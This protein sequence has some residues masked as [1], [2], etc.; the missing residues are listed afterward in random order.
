MGRSSFP[1]HTP[2][3][4]V[5]LLHLVEAQQHTAVSRLKDAATQA[6]AAAAAAATTAAASAAV[7]QARAALAV[8]RRLGGLRA[9]LQRT[10]VRLQR[11]QQQHQHQHQQHQQ[12]ANSTPKGGSALT[13]GALT[14]TACS[15]PP[16]LAAQLRAG[17]DCLQTAARVSPL[18]D[19]LLLCCDL[20]QLCCCPPSLGSEALHRLLQLLQ[21]V[22]RPQEPPELRAQEAALGLQLAALLVQQNAAEVAAAA[23]GQQTLSV[24]G[25]CIGR[26]QASIASAPASADASSSVD[27]PKEHSKSSLQEHHGAPEAGVR[28]QGAML[29]LSLLVSMQLLELLAHRKDMRR[30]L[31]LRTC[32]HTAQACALLAS[33]EG[34]MRYMT[35]QQEAPEVFAAAVHLQLSSAFTAAH[36]RRIA[37]TALGL[38]SKQEALHALAESSSALL[39]Q[40][41]RVA[42]SA[43]SSDAAE[44]PCGASVPSGP[45][46]QL[47][48]TADYDAASR[49][50]AAALLRRIQQVL[51]PRLS[52]LLLVEAARRRVLPG[53]GAQQQMPHEECGWTNRL[54]GAA[55]SAAVRATPT[56]ATRKKLVLLLLHRLKQQREQQQ[57]QQ[58]QAWS[59]GDGWLMAILQEICEVSAFHE[60]HRLALSNSKAVRMSPAALASVCR[61]L[62]VAGLSVNKGGLSFLFEQI[63]ISLFGCTGFDEM[64]S[65]RIP[66]LAGEVEGGDDKDSRAADA[67]ALATAAPFADGWSVAAST[68]PA[69]NSCPA[70][71]SAA[72]AETVAAYGSW[73]TVFWATAKILKASCDS[74]QPS[75][76]S[77]LKLQRLFVRKMLESLVENIAAAEPGEAA[78]IAE[79]LRLL[80]LLGLKAETHASRN[81]ESWEERRRPLVLRQR[82]VRAELL[83]KAVQGIT[84]HFVEHHE[85]FGLVEV[86]NV[87]RLLVQLDLLQHMDGK[88]ATEEAPAPYGQ[89][90]NLVRRQGFALQPVED[91]CSKLRWPESGREGELSE[92][93]E[94][95]AQGLM[96]TIVLKYPEEL[97]RLPKT[98]TKRV[99]KQAGGFPEKAL[100]DAAERSHRE[101]RSL[102][103][104]PRDVK[105]MIFAA[106][107]ANPKQAVIQ[108]STASLVE[109]AWIQAFCEISNQLS[110][111]R[112]PP[113]SGPEEL[114]RMLG[115]MSPSSSME[116]LEGEQ[117]KG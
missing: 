115:S 3:D 74:V 38:T 28:E 66:P 30:D 89:Y 22:Q 33:Q 46:Q 82:L 99:L 85:R 102:L 106:N 50:S 6:A 39:S 10:S 63:S 112:V 37:S 23:G 12:F 93:L 72:V 92:S 45:F 16:T 31:T 86:L 49:L 76:S 26:Q 108:E 67:P 71:A 64:P 101:R 90:L 13:F 117:E 97:Q 69:A 5:K 58:Q 15:L 55:M 54:L 84:S 44:V 59:H 42:I 62:A 1:V 17:V 53:A 8:V 98:L 47:R 110:K 94:S 2:E 91:G 25:S 79:G 60:Q 19:L 36:A 75:G 116:R 41:S 4:A 68:K 77:D 78:Q 61:S 109:D 114:L 88:L 56:Y 34:I 9:H 105:A 80:L 20:T 100:L 83:L 104:A 52:A 51:A 24:L 40:P 70:A 29:Q 57:E 73:C 27:I 21:Q 111:L 96:L 87:L 103:G 35:L 43:R 18:R 48:A 95:F 32:V 11:L 14:D 81:K 113:I 107:F 7:A 65:H